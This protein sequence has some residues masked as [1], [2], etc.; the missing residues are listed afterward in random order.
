MVADHSLWP[1][2][3]VSVRFVF[4]LACRSRW[5]LDTVSL[6]AIFF[7]FF[8]IASRWHALSRF[9]EPAGGYDMWR[10]KIFPSLSIDAFVV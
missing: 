9:Y 8:G 5:L 3:G 1:E 10:R 7:F 4:L 2:S 6:V